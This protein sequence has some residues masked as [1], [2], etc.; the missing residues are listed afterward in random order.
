[1]RDLGEFEDFLHRNL[2]SD[3][4]GHAIDIAHDFLV[5]ADAPNSSLNQK[6]RLLLLAAPIAFRQ[7]RKFGIQFSGNITNQK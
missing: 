4:W 1:M 6:Q 2:A 3:L 5:S 7:G